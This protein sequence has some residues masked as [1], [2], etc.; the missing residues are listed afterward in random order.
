MGFI[1]RT[2]KLFGLGSLALAAARIH[3][4]KVSSDGALDGF[5]G[6]RHYATRPQ[7]ASFEGLAGN[8]GCHE[9]PGAGL[10]EVREKRPFGGGGRVRRGL[11]H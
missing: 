4:Y 5:D 8:E 2:A 6:V 3:E 7:S 10:A 1:D 11:R 9:G